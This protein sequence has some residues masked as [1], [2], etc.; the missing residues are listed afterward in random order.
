M[1]KIIIEHEDAKSSNIKGGRI[2]P[3]NTQAILNIVF[4]KQLTENWCWAAI[5]KMVYQYYYNKDISQELIVANL[6]NV[7]VK[8]LK[9]KGKVIKKYNKEMVLNQTLE[10]LCCFSHWSLGKPTFERL[11]HE[12]NQGKPL[13]CRIEWYSGNAHYVLIH[14]Y[15]IESKSLYITD[16]QEGKSLVHYNEFPKNYKNKGG[17]WTET[18]WTCKKTINTNL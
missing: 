6:F 3:N 8:S 18:F 15:D 14:G 10:D 5:S 2:L 7:D 9:T 4:E 17:A 12:I 16:S 13:C 1:L 11:Q